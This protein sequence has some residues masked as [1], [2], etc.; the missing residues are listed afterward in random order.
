MNQYFESLDATIAAIKADCAE[1]IRAMSDK[2]LA[3]E[4]KATLCEDQLNR[5]ILAKED[6]LN[7][8]TRLL[9]QFE[10]AEKAFGDAKKFA[11]V[12]ERPPAQADHPLLPRVEIS[13]EK[14]NSDERRIS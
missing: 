13:E 8:A 3:A 2:L 4:V 12:L 6:A 11:L 5:A 9:T 10:I 1:Q 14:D 7:I